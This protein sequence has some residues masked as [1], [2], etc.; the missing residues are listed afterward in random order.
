ME[1]TQE[2]NM[3]VTPALIEDA[4][5]KAREIYGHDAILDRPDQEDREYAERI[6]NTTPEETITAMRET[7]ARSKT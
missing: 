2:K 4:C 5:L 3:S 1:S 7:A 6:A